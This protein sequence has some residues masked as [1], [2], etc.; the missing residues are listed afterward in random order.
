MDGLT[1]SIIIMGGLEND[2]ILTEIYNTKD[3][4]WIQGPTLPS[5]E[6]CASCAPLPPTS[7]Y[8][9]IFIGIGTAKNN[10]SSNVYGLNKNFTEWTLLGKTKTGSD[11]YIALPLS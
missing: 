1:Q 3:E 6:R 11:C 7:I 10:F 8:A 5:E 2:S 9:C 4:M